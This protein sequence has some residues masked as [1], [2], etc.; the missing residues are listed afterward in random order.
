MPPFPGMEIE[1][2]SSNCI[3]V[4]FG[5]LGLSVQPSNSP[6]VSKLQ[7]DRPRQKRSWQRSRRVSTIHVCIKVV[8]REAS[9]LCVPHHSILKRLAVRVIHGMLSRK[10]NQPLL[11]YCAYSLLHLALQHGTKIMHKSYWI[12]STFLLNQG[13]RLFLSS[14]WTSFFLRMFCT[15]VRHSWSVSSMVRNPHTAINAVMKE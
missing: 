10:C 1:T 13:S 15:S 3:W 11:E 14:L 4:T 5:L 12:Y 2:S 8:S 9:K 7:R 6:E